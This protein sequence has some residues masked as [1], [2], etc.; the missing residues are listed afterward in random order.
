MVMVERGG[1]GM[2]EGSLYG[3]DDEVMMASLL[4]MEVHDN[5]VCDDDGDGGGD[6]YCDDCQCSCSK[7]SESK[8][9]ESTERSH[10]YYFPF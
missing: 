8:S 1:P 3:V 5:D 6:C 2:G 9:S 10:C 7:S 4:V